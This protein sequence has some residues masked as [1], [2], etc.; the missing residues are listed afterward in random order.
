MV[1]RL[2]SQRTVNKKIYYNLP[3][4]ARIQHKANFLKMFDGFFECFFSFCILGDTYFFKYVI[5]KRLQQHRD[6]D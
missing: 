2:F 3:A 4:E 6:A 5:K 1:I